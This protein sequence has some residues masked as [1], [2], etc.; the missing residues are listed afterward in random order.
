MVMN[1]DLA[2]VKVQRLGEDEW[3]MALRLA[4]NY[5]D[6]LSVYSR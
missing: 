5:P 2:G 6:T 1:W 3:D 4:Y